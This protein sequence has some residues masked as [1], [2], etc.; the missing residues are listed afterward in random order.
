MLH[1]LHHGVTRPVSALRSCVPDAGTYGETTSTSPC[2]RVPSDTYLCK[3]LHELL[4]RV[5]FC[6]MDFAVRVSASA[7]GSNSYA[8]NIPRITCARTRPYETRTSERAS[9]G[10]AMAWSMQHEHTC[11]PQVHTQSHSSYTGAV[12]VAKAAIAIA[13]ATATAAANAA[14]N[15]ASVQR[16]TPRQRSKQDEANYYINSKEQP[17]SHASPARHAHFLPSYSLRG[18]HNNKLLTAIDGVASYLV[19]NTHGSYSLP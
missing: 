9:A 17:Q 3:D 18:T 2:N 14:A 11:S 8:H 19:E 15:A 10:S 13:T 12:A 16:R 6:I 5:N 4:S 1:T 7:L